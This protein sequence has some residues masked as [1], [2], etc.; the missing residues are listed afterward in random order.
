MW[1]PG[2]GVG[3]Y[4]EGGRVLGDMMRV[5]FFGGEGGGNVCV[6]GGKA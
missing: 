5:F 1:F 6:K 2:F 4:K 3:G